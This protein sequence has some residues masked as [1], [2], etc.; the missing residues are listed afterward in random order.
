MYAYRVGLTR[1]EIQP[2]RAW[3][4]RFDGYN[5]LIIILRCYINTIIFCRLFFCRRR[6]LTSYENPSAY[7]IIQ[8]RR[9]YLS[10]ILF[11][12]TIFHGLSGRCSRTTVTPA[13]WS[14]CP[15]WTGAT[16]CRYTPITNRNN[17][18]N[19]IMCNVRDR[20]R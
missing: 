9:V 8:V 4:E 12:T 17:N 14:S 1:R 6:R 16:R 19:I 11:C 5:L 3:A 15:P 2:R 7:I 20:C 13:H 18:N 10:I